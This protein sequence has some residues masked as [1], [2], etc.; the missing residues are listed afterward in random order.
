[1]KPGGIAYGGEVFLKQV[2]VLIEI[3]IIKGYAYLLNVEWKS[4]EQ[5]IREL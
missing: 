3:L 2:M 5:M 1:L 4:E